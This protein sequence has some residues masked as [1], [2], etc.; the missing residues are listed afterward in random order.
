MTR[1]RGGPGPVRR[2]CAPWM[3]RREAQPLCAKRGARLTSA[4]WA[5]RQG[6]PKGL[7]PKPL[8]PPGAPFPSGKEKGKPACP[9]PFK[10]QGR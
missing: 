3:E 5:L 9:A 8:A 4:R 1:F 2:Q 6:S 7:A 10:E